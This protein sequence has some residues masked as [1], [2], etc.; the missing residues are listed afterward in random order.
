MGKKTGRKILLFLAVVT[1]LQ[2]LAFHH[3][4]S[5]LEV[6]PAAAAEQPTAPQT[7]ARS[8]QQSAQTLAQLQQAHR[9][10]AVSNDQ[11]LA[12]YVD[13]Q[14]NTV[15]VVNL[16]DG[17]ETAV[18]PM[19]APV[20]FLQWIENT[21]LFAG[22]KF[23]ANGDHR[24]ALA[25]LGLSGQTVRLV[26]TFT[27]MSSSATFKGVVYSSY[28]NDVYIW[29]G[30][31]QSD[32]VYHFDIN[33]NFSE[34]PLG[35]RRVVKLAVSQTT[36]DL[37]LGDFAA[38]TYNVLVYSKHT[39]E[40]IQRNAVLLQTVGNDMYYGTLNSANQV[41]AVYKYSQ[42][43]AGLVQSLMTP[44]PVDHIHVSDNGTVTVQAG[45]PS[46]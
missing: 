21:S 4:D 25:T 3:Y 7:Q 26:K 24:L 34:I 35:G 16:S 44:V 27:G 23:T 15:H 29:I 40:L 28:T 17:Q 41:T 20:V 13:S 45:H 36:N 37:Y 43:H 30:G 2:W 39:W 10:V 1:P 38:G 9:V 33:N 22:E 14:D 5:L 31:D 12:A 42:G 32:L 8:A 46:P 11:Q 6:K 19:K 18:F